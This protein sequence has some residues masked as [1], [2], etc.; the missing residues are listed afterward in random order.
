MDLITI[1]LLCFICFIAGVAYGQFRQ[2]LKIAEKM[3]L[4]PDG[5]IKTIQKVQK[6]IKSLKEK[7]NAGVGVDAVEVVIEKHGDTYYIYRA[8]NDQFLGQGNDRDETLKTISANLGNINLLAK[9]TKEVSQ[10]A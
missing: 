3:T 8:D 9:Q 4:D 2:T 6:E 7:E 1:M 10:T 5:M